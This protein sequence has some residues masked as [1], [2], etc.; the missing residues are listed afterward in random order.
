MFGKTP[1]STI[2]KIGF[3]PFSDNVQKPEMFFIFTRPYL[4]GNTLYVYNQLHF[5]LSILQGVHY[6]LRVLLCCMNW[7]CKKYQLLYIQGV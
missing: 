1:F 7:L 4:Q 3:K 5:V 2:I 6:K